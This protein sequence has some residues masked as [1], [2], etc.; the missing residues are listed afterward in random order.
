V[1]VADDDG[2]VC[3]PRAEAADALSRAHAR[4]ATEQDKRKQLAERVLG[5]DLY[6]LCDVLTRLRVRYIKQNNGRSGGTP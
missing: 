3:V 6:G 1:I 4:L 5:L 2:V